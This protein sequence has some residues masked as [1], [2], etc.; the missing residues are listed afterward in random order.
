MFFP[1]QDLMVLY[2]QNHVSWLL[3]A[4]RELAQA[5][6]TQLGIHEATNPAGGNKE[7]YNIETH[8]HLERS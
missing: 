3:H 5:I 8:E 7:L 1:T 2:G 4:H 6:A